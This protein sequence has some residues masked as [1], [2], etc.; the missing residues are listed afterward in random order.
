M[1]ESI[2]TLDSLELCEGLRFDNTATET[3]C[4]STVKQMKNTS[5]KTSTS[6]VVEE[7]TTT[8]HHNFEHGV[9]LSVD[10]DE[11]KAT[12]QNVEISGFQAENSETK[13]IA[14][15]NVDSD[16]NAFKD[17]DCNTPNGNESVWPENIINIVTAILN[18]PIR[19]PEKPEFMF[20][21]TMEAA[22][23]NY[24]L[25]IKKYG[26]SLEKAVKGNRKSPM[27]LGSEFRPIEVLKRI[28]HLHPKWNSMV[29]I[30]CKGSKWPLETLSEKSRLEDLREAIE[31]GNHKGA[32][33]ESNLL[34][35]LVKKDVKFGYAI[36]FPLSKVTSIPGV[37]MAPMNIMH[38]GT[39]D[40][41]GK[42]VDKKR[43]THDQSYK[44]KSG[45]SIN[46][47][48]IDADLSPCMYGACLRRI[49]NWACA[50]RTKHPNVRIY[51]S[52]VDIKSAYRRC[53]LHPEIALQSCTQIALTND[54]NLMIMMLRLTFGGKPCPSEWSILAEPICDLA[55]AI[56]Q[57]DSWDPTKLKSPY[58]N[59]VPKPKTKQSVEIE[60]LAS[61]KDLI[62]DIP[63]NN[64]GT[65]DIYIDD[66][67]ALTLDIPGSNN[68]ERCS[69]A[70]LLAIEATARPSHADEPIPREEM[71]ALNKLIAEAG[72]E[73]EKTILGWKMDFNGLII[74][75]PSNKFQ[76]WSDG[77]SE[78][79]VNGRAKAK[80][81]ESLIGRLGHLGA[82][83]PYVFHFLSRLREWHHRS[84]NKRHPT[85]MST[86]C[87]LDLMLMLDFLHKAK[88]GVDM[89]IV[90]YRK[91][92]NIYRSDSC[93]F[94]LGGYS[95]EGFA[96][97]FEIPQ[98]LRFRAS[99][100]LLEF[101]A[102]IISPWI[103]V[104]EGRLNK[105]DCV[106]SMTDSTTSAGWIRKTNFKEDGD[107]FNKI[108]ASVRIE[109]ARHHASLMINAGIKEYS[110][111][112]EGKKNQV[113]DALSREFELTKQ[114]LTNTL[115]S[116]FPSQ[117]PEHFEIV[118][119]PIEISSWLISL[120]QKLP[121]KEQLREEHTKAKLDPGDDS[122]CTSCQSDLKTTNS[123]S[124]SPSLNKIESCVRSPWLCG[125]DDFQRHL[126]TDWL[127]EQSKI[128]FRMYVRPSGKMECQTL[129]RTRTDNLASFYQDY[130]EPL[131]M[132]TQTKSNRK[133][134]HPASSFQ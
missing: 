61:G 94:G 71:A 118:Q 52:K 91:P 10:N 18:I 108:E 1:K 16:S 23:R 126:M 30:L 107:D 25:L 90:S 35:E 125:K 79:L 75:L 69:G 33:V 47:R 114:N 103:D 92:T 95:C 45:T 76:A 7:G 62:V 72:P 6:V 54:D 39:I 96:W 80:E 46:S 87:R 56:L 38:Q 85:Q 111:W 100:N 134:C 40:E 105:G 93:P 22:E 109:I 20:E 124:L 122:S 60:N 116:S 65:H 28:Y 51:A 15:F 11:G 9:N 55:T 42:I 50:A 24:Q 83:I 117:L 74:S 129:Q 59:L 77:I 81:L 102:S 66:I 112:F 106:L 88:Q 2:N 36:P 21:L 64:R 130:T 132:K 110:Q 119:L 29:P 17:N 14:G 133:R 37:V 84:K 131:G 86:E 99:N 8:L 26:G 48:V 78:M 67:I 19:K 41:S 31:F 27:G 82:I 34:T 12:Q 3:I 89:N 43:L 128:P 63:I 13:P 32:K 68:L 123:L 104:L 70:H 44:F 49:I 121:V 57:D 53:H 98:E 101:I 5:V 113:A 115:R 97:Q 73:E 127:R 120:L 4:V 58:Q